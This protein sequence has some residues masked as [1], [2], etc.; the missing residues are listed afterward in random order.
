MYATS[1]LLASATTAAT[2]QIP[3]FQY[4]DI[5]GLPIQWFGL[6]VA[7][8]V[9]IGAGVLRRY[10]E[11][12]G[13]SDDHIRR[14]STWVMATG[15]LG[16]HLFDVIAYQGHK[17]WFAIGHAHPS[18]HGMHPG[19]WP[20]IFRIWDGI[21]S[22]GGFLGGAMGWFFY[23]WWHRLPM[24]LA[25]DTTVTGLLVAFTI[26]RIGCTVVS[27]H[28]GAAVDPDSWYSVFAMP[29]PRTMNNEVIIELARANPGTGDIWAWNLGFVEFLYL[30]LVN[31]LILW[32]AFRPK[33][34]PAGFVTALTGVLYAPVRFFLDYLR[35]ENSDPRHFGFTFAQW[36]S[37]LAFGAAAYL[38]L[39][40]LK[41][42]QVAE[43]IAPTSKEAQAKLT[44]AMNEAAP[45]EA[46]KASPAAAV[47]AKVDTMTDEQRKKA[48]EL[49]E[50]RE[51]ERKAKENADEIEAAERRRKQDEEFE[52]KQAAKNEA[53][54]AAKSAN[55]DNP[56]DEGNVDAQTAKD[57]AQPAATT[58]KGPPAASGGKPK[59]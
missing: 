38:A 45:P 26:G 51:A 57:L 44:A 34:T 37:L 42:G 59:R 4:T 8:G 9:L 19:D 49:E 27:D 21:S 53:A 50:A 20:L 10:G 13:I 28:I 7:I 22:Y 12:H 24:R 32:L 41:N 18:W 40:I 39:R 11:W 55:L 14:L 25:A 58:A 48:K 29:Y 3:F 46:K 2:T 1:L 43:T 56:A 31:V 33:R 30:V 15:F 47:K 36:A 54:A 6:I 35:P 52:R 5:F 23:V 17:D 16:A